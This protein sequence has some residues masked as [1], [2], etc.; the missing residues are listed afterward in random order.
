MPQREITY[1][2]E[3]ISGNLI[4]YGTYHDLGDTH[5]ITAA[6][7]VNFTIN[8]YTLQYLDYNG[9]WRNVKVTPGITADKK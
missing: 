8:R 1:R 4:V 2:A 5:R 7:K 6:C 9:K 3:T